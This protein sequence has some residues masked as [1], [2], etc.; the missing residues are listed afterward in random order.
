[1]KADASLE[2]LAKGVSPSAIRDYAKATGWE[3]VREGVKGRIYLLRHSTD[4]LR[5]LV[6]PMDFSD[7]YAEVIVDATSRIASLEGRPTQAVLTDLLTPDADILRF[8]VA[9][10]D[11][12]VTL[13]LQEGID[14]LDGAKKALLAAACSVVSP[15]SHHP[16]MGRSET[17][18]LLGAC[19]LGQTEQGSFVVKIA[20]PLS[21]VDRRPSEIPFVR[22]TTELLLKSAHRIVDAIERDQVDSVFDQS[23]E[24]P[25]I[26]SNLCDAILQM[27]AT[28]ENA[29]LAISAQWASALPG[30]VQPNLPTEVKF[31]PD[32]FDIVEDIYLRLRPSEGDS[33]SVFVGTVET[34]NGDLG[35]DGRRFGEVIL[36][37]FNEDEILRARLTLKAEQYAIAD[38]AHM[39]GNMVVLKGTLRRGRRV[40]RITELESF[41][42]FRPSTEVRR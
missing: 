6:I 42:P 34:L 17:A 12:D 33:Q 10:R 32:Y 41:E 5:Q 26:S 35:E 23:L 30:P 39:N 20:C 27:Q 21:A 22:K 24:L 7:D 11:V 19:R 31:N 18:Q 3:Q 25:T 38:Q 8:R 4:R 37:L 14:L 2:R 28:K 36:Y 40:H 9:T 13:P 15:Q 1:M 29:S 16:R